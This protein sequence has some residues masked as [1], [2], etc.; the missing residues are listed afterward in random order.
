MFNACLAARLR[1]GLLLRVLSGDV[2]MKWPYGGMFVAE[3]LP[4]EQQRLEAKEIVPSGPMFGRKMF[5][6]KD[7]AARREAQ[8]LAD[9]GL[10]MEAFGGWQRS[11]C[12]GVSR[13]EKH[14]GRILLC[15]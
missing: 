9:A 11:R 13:T 12:H 8:A 3:D 1:D 2:M 6:S 14:V 10:T 5:A 15:C 7:E 4:R